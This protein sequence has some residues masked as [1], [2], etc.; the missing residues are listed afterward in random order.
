LEVNY[1]IIVDTLIEKTKYVLELIPSLGG[2]V[3]NKSSNVNLEQK[4]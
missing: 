2:V 1:W 3:W 4:L